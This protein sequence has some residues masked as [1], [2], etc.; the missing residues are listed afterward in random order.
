MLTLIGSLACCTLKFKSLLVACHHKNYLGCHY[1]LEDEQELSLGTLI[2]P[3]RI[4]NFC[5]FH[6]CFGDNAICFDALSYH[7]QLIW[8][9][10]LTKCL[11]FLSVFVHAL[12]K[13]GE[14]IKVLGKI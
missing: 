2:R 9:N 14:K 10:L 1:L 11:L 6:A 3:K 12:K 7:L 5:L 13:K 8:T 4:Y